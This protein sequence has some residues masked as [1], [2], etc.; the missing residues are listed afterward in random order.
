MTSEEEIAL[1]R[2][3][4]D[5][6]DEHIMKL[7]SERVNLAK[8]IGKV[9]KKFNRPVLDSGRET[10][11]YKKIEDSAKQLGT[12][13]EDCITVFKEIIKLCRNAENIKDN[14]D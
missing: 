2:K 7:L 3:R 4:I 1:L 10:A 14:A 13:P 9:K 12:S 5:A 6:V 11:I 8:D